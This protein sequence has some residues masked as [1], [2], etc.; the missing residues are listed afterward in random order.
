[1]QTPCN[2][3]ENVL[4]GSFNK[5]FLSFELS[6][7]NKVTQNEMIIFILQIEVRVRG[8]GMK[9]MGRLI[10]PSWWTHRAISS[11]SIYKNSCRCRKEQS[12]EWL[13]QVSSLAQ[14]SFTICSM[15]YTHK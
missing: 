3:K 13:Q 12:M 1:M 4:R 10:D 5:T 9:V 2:R 14:W 7:D 15:I 8:A 6:L 11:L